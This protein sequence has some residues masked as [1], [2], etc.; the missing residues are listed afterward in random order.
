MLVSLAYVQQEL[1]LPSLGTDETGGATC[2]RT[3]VSNMKLP[4]RLVAK[5]MH[6]DEFNNLLGGVLY[7][8][9]AKNYNSLPTA[10]LSGLSGG[11]QKTISVSD[12]NNKQGSISR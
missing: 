6:I 9:D 5:E 12:V 7:S 2:T 10:F 3:K 1:D 8:L 4:N 11:K